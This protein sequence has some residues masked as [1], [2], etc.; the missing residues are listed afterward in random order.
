[1]ISMRFASLLAGTSP[2]Y[3]SSCQIDQNRHHPVHSVLP[4]RSGPSCP[5][6]C[7][8]KC[9]AAP[10]IC[11]LNWWAHRPGLPVGCVGYSWA[12]GS[13]P[14]PHF[15]PMKHWEWE[16]NEPSVSGHFDLCFTQNFAVRD[17]MDDQFLTRARPVG[18]TGGRRITAIWYYGF[19]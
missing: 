13:H 7:P 14:C 11:R 12:F 15:Q 18:V 4:C 1:M 6:P 17:V 5:G 19:H 3:C 8:V 2:R 9:T 16:L 10:L